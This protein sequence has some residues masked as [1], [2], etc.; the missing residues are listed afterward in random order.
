[1]SELGIVLWALVI[2]SPLIVAL[3][4]ILLKMGALKYGKRI[5]WRQYINPIV[6]SAYVLFFGVTVINVYLFSVFPLSLGSI[7][8]AIS[9]IGVVFSGRLIFGENLSSIQ[10]CGIVITIFGMMLY[11]IGIRIQ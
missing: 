11:G 9:Y 1:M 7:M 10:I 4:Q 6:I 3:S 5:W 2:I 8:V